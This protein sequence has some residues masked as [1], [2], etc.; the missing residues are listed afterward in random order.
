[1]K[2]TYVELAIKIAGS[3]KALGKILGRP[4]SLIHAW[5]YNQKKVSVSSVPE[6]VEFTDGKVKAHELRPDLPKVF[7]HTK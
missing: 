2:N 1:M 4:Q 6:I 3:Q 7:P 5:L